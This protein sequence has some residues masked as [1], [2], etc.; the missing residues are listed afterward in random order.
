MHCCAAGTHG[1]HKVKLGRARSEVK[2]AAD[3]DVVDWA[4]QTEAMLSCCSSNHLHG[5]DRKV[6][7]QFHDKSLT[8]ASGSIASCP[9]DK[10]QSGGMHCKPTRSQIHQQTRAKQL[11]GHNVTDPPG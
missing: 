11:S 1:K 4:L 5:N 2:L 9:E 8:A 7:T 6:A 3:R 10:M